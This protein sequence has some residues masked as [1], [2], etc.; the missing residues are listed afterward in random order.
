MFKISN[1]NAFEN[2]MLLSALRTHRLFKDNKKRHQYRTVSVKNLNQKY[3]HFGGLLEL[4][5]YKGQMIIKPQGRK[6]V[7][8]QLSIHLNSNQNDVTAGV[9]TADGNMFWHP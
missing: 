2:I 1:W 8:A 6:A 3:T 4:T 9:L 7:T 5:A